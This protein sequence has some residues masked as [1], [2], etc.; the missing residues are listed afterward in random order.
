MRSRVRPEEALLAGYGVALVAI[1]AA[2]GHWTFTSTMHR[3]FVDVFLVLALGVLARD[4]WRSRRQLRS[5]WLALRQRAAGSG[6]G[7]S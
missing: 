3:H 7:H 6:A 5:G 1:M 4:F 2:T